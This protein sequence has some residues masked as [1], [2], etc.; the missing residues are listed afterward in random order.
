MKINFYG[1]T[2]NDINKA[3]L[4]VVIQDGFGQVLASLSEQIQLPFSSDLVEA[5]AT[6]R[7][8]SF[9]AEFGFSRF[10]LEG[11]STKHYR[12]RKTH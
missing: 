4:G 2:F 5:M 6:A 7:A 3:G 1:A 9:V 11:D 10:I 8:L 12:A